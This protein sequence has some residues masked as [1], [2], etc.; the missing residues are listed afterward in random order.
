MKQI[1][2]GSFLTLHYRLSG[3]Q[4]D[5]IINTFEGPPATLTLGSGELAPAIEQRLVGLSEGA[6]EVF[7]IP[8]GETFGQ[9]NPEMQ[10]KV[11]ATKSPASQ[12]TSQKTFIRTVTMSKVEPYCDAIGTHR[13]LVTK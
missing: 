5:T 8:A 6:H 1:Q 12:M 10:Q 2:P 11:N 3:L 9:R 4:G 13:V 7:D